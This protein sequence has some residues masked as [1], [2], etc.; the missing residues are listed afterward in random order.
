MTSGS[1]SSHRK[2]IA[3]VH[4]EPDPT[5][6]ST[7]SGLSTFGP[8]PG[9]RDS[10]G[11][12]GLIDTIQAGTFPGYSSLRDLCGPTQ[13]STGS[14]EA[15]GDGVEYEITNTAP[16]VVGTLRHSYNE[17]YDGGPLYVSAE[18][19]Q[20]TAVDQPE[21]AGKNHEPSQVQNCSGQDVPYQGV[22]DGG[23]YA[24]PHTDG[25]YAR[26]DDGGLYSKPQ[27]SG[28]YASPDGPDYDS[29]S[30]GH[31]DGV[32]D[33]SCDY[34]STGGASDGHYE[35]LPCADSNIYEAIEFGKSK[36]SR[37]KYRKPDSRSGAATNSIN[38]T[39]HPQQ[40]PLPPPLPAPLA[41]G[42]L[43][44]TRPLDDFHY[45]VNNDEYAIVRKPNRQPS[46]ISSSKS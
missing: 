34:E 22:S 31:Y 17:A 27:D 29:P 35:S 9:G 14:L 43:N 30:S 42:G 36:G 20:Y 37:K 25:P 16:A 23:H 45:C 1:E 13:I 28:L 41:N 6:A 3:S 33:S 24:T 15:G 8:G 4:L 44:H 2:V 46:A 26:I 12:S 18:S 10:D 40:P 21:S 11:L 32:G 7:G 5:R 38:S 39:K 19:G